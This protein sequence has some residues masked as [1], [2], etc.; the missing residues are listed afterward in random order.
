MIKYHLESNKDFSSNI[1]NFKKNGYPDGI[2]VEIFSFKAIK[3]I[4]KY[5]KNK[6]FREHVALNFYDYDK[7]RPYTR[8]N[9]KLGTIKCPKD[10]SRP[11]LVLDVNYKKDLIFI[12]KIY[13]FFK[14]N[15]D[16]SIKDVIKWYD[17]YYLAK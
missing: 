17:R 1:C 6:R 4:W 3:K 16:F 13:S 11:K 7:K 15:K 2:G 5:Q 12:K 9:F 8:F 14:K 10:I